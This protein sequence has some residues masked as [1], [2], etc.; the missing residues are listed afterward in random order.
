MTYTIA[1]AP[2][3]AP[4]K[5]TFTANITEDNST[6]KVDMLEHNTS[7]VG[8]V[9]EYQVVHYQGAIK[10]ES[11]WIRF[12]SDAADNAKLD[13]AMDYA[14]TNYY[15]YARYAGNDNYHPSA[16]TQADQHYFYKGKVNIT[17][18]TK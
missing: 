10:H 4:A 18:N 5:P 11:D 14:L 9:A 8:T 1:K 16:A 3:A 13:F 7:S 12:A 17:L 15:V 2:Q 6:L